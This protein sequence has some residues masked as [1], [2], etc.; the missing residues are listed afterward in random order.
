MANHLAYPTNVLLPPCMMRRREVLTLLR[1]V[2]IFLV[3][4]SGSSKSLEDV[5]SCEQM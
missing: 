1:M 2:D 4:M 5:T 3:R